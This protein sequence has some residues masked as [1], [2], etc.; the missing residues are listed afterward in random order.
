MFLK[1]TRFAIIFGLLSVSLTAP[2]AGPQWWQQIYSS[3][4]NSQITLK[5]QNNTSVTAITNPTAASVQLNSNTNTQPPTVVVQASASLPVVAIGSACTF[6]T[7]TAALS[8]ADRLT[9]LTCNSSNLWAIANRVSL[10]VVVAGN[11]CNITTDGN[12]GVD[13]SGMLLSCQ[14]GMWSSIGV[15]SGRMLYAAGS[16][17]C[18]SNE[19]VLGCL[20]QYSNGTIDP[21]TISGLTCIAWGGYAIGSCATR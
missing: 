5:D 4:T 7:S 3:N 10:P 8:S 1:L 21:G 17:T 11:A 20:S 19:V 18:S 16:V 13:A 9:L 12:A 6:G 14:S 15:R 2:A